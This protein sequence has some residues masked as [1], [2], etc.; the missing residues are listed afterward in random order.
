MKYFYFLMLAF[1]SLTVSTACDKADPIDTVGEQE[2]DT[3]F[4]PSENSK[5]LVAYFSA[6]GN[7]QRVAERIA[8]LTDADLYRIEPK[9]P[10][11]E[12][13]YDDSDR[14]QNEAYDDL[15]PEV[16]NLPE[17][18]DGYDT[19][20]IGSPIWWHQPAMVVCTFLEHMT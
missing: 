10:Y 11:A 13:P 6:T 3:P 7:T 12:N 9:H 5:V 17:S 4:E 14:I 16:S 2:Q 20:Y 18:L 8:E 1:V 19:I 15:R